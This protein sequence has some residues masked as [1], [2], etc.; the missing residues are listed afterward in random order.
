[1]IVINR[2]SVYLGVFFGCTG[3]RQRTNREFLMADKSMSIVPVSMSLLARSVRHYVP[4]LVEF[5]GSFTFSVLSSALCR[6]WPYWVRLQKYT[7]TAPCTYGSLSPTV[8]VC[9]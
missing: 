8:S 1:M 6:Q 2:R 5:A 7:P 9:S 3:G 4:P